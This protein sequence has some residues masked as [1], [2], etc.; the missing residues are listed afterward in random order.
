MLVVD[1]E[2]CKL[3]RLCFLVANCAAE[4][5]I[6]L[7]VETAPDLLGDLFMVLKMGQEHVS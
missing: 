4:L 2:L 6:L 3:F 7:R 1:M 5:V